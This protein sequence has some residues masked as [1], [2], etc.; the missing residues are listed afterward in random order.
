MPPCPVLYGANSGANNGCL[1]ALTR[2]TDDRLNCLPRLVIELNAL[3]GHG[4]QGSAEGNHSE[5][6]VSA[7]HGPVVTGHNCVAPVNEIGV[8][9]LA[10]LRLPDNEA[11]HLYRLAFKLAKTVETF[12]LLLEEAGH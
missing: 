2:L 4:R 7:H 9:V 6:R 1:K 11:K 8:Q 12:S 3:T 5:R 10:A